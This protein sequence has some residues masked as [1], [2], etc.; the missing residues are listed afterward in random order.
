MTPPSRPSLTPS[1]SKTPVSPARVHRADP[2]ETPPAPEGTP[3]HVFRRVTPLPQGSKPA[4]SSTPA[5]SSE[6]QISSV[7]EPR[8]PDSQMPAQRRP[9]NPPARFDDP[10]KDEGGSRD[11]KTAVYQQ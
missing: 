9:V 2:S 1:H 3:L 4:V 10:R 11:I 8:V 5:G 6:R 7:H